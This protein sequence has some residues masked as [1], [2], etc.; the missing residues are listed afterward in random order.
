MNLKQILKLLPGFALMV[1]ILTSASPINAQTIQTLFSFNGTDG[2]Y[3]RALTLG[4]DGNFYGTTREGGNSGNSDYPSG[5]GTFFEITTEGAFT[6]L[7]NFNQGAY[8]SA[9]TLDANNDNFYGTAME[10]G[11][12]NS[13]YPDG[14]GTVFMVTPGGLL[15][16]LLSFTN[17]D[18]AF[19]AASLTLGKDGNFYGTTENGG[20][21]NLNLNSG[22]G[23]IF[24][25][26]PSG[27]L[28]NLVNFNDTDGQ[29][30]NSLTLYNDGSL[31][32]TAA[33]G[34]NGSGTVFKASTNGTF[35]WTISLNGN[36]GI[37]PSAALT[38]GA[39]GNLFGTTKNGGDDSF[40]TIFKITTNGILTTLFSFSFDTNGAYPS[41]ALLL[42]N[43]G[44]FYGTSTEGGNLNLNGGYGYGTVFKITTNGVLTTLASFA[45]TNG[46]D[47]QAALTLD[48]NGNIYGT[49][50][51]GGT[52][53]NGT[54]FR[55]L[56]PAVI[57]VQPQNQTNYAGTTVTFL[58]SASGLEPM[59]YQWQRDGTNL[60]DDGD[61][62]GAT[63]DALTITNVSDN[64]AA[65][66]SV[67][68]ANT[69]GSSTS[70]NATLTVDD[71]PFI[72]LQPQSQTAG[73]GNTVTFKATVYG[74]PPFVFQWYFNGTPLGSSAVGTGD[75]SYALTD[76]GTNQAGVY[77][78]HIFNDY[79]S[80]TS[81][82]ALL[83]VIPQP[84][85]K[86]QFV[87]GYP[88]LNLAGALGN[89]YVVQ[90]NTNLASSSWVNLRS[91]TNLSASPYQFLDSA[92]FGQPARFY[93]TFLQ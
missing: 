89:N 51:S 79:G 64:D 85:L 65:V 37:S 82:N 3:P 32:G 27:V 24:R 66:Y 90:Y 26:T 60:V 40:G 16:T 56:L 88:L 31:F 9:L 75:I 23:G 62:S 19:P 6:S 47:P 21:T 69:G 35:A 8:P 46:S 4:A 45:G 72:A 12:S 74:A 44:N 71:L 92:G 33:G 7:L 52:N 1:L 70:S 30:P 83:T 29:D 38:V 68:V 73:V 67:I 25:V 34:G 2:T 50:A 63:N 41:A 17:S 42:G 91:I 43:D 20:N 18:G 77:G 76:I 36:N 55:L 54:I 49:T 93:R 81:S 14:M 22:Y 80:A 57:T 58:V 5:M 28:T 11:V 39:D 15:T 84:T 86:L 78:V 53:G 59:S 87:A 61:I 48:G 10:G 13:K